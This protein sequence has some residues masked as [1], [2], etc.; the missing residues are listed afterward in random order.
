MARVTNTASGGADDAAV[1]L[2]AMPDVRTRYLRL[3]V[4]R[5]PGCERILLAEL[6]VAGP[7]PAAGTRDR[8]RPDRCWPSPPPCRSSA[9]ST[10]PCSMPAS[11]SS[12]A[13]IPPTSSGTGD[14]NLAGITIVNRSGRQAVR[15]KV[16]IDATDRGVAARLAGA[17]FAPY[18]AGNQT[19]SRIVLGGDR[20]RDAQDLGANFRVDGRVVKA[21][22]YRLELPMRDGS[23]AVLCPGRPG[24]PRT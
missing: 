9:A 2:R 5:A 7:A 18:P 17:R 13:P 23:L 6:H 3:T 15:A 1:D 20:G 8:T 12:T 11:T 21:Y 22:G 19:F 16:I 24:G 10:T 4:T 14:G